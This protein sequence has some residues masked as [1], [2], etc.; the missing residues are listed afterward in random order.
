METGEGQRR[1]QDPSRLRWSSDL[2]H[3][4]PARIKARVTAWYLTKRAQLIRKR[5][6]EKAER[7]FRRAGA[8]IEAAIGPDFPEIAE[9]LIGLGRC[10]YERGQ[11]AEGLPVYERLARIYRAEFG[12][13]AQPTAWVETRIAVGLGETGRLD[14]AS[15]LL[16]G[17]LAIYERTYG[18]KHRYVAYV[19]DLLGE[20]SRLNN[21]YDEAIGYFERALAIRRRGF[22]H[23]GIKWTTT[24]LAISK[25]G[26]GVEQ[27]RACLLD[28][29]ESTLGQSRQLAL[30]IGRENEV[31]VLVEGGL[32]MVRDQQGRYRE[33]ENHFRNMYVK[34]VD[35]NDGPEV[36]LAAAEFL[37]DVLATL[38]R[39]PDALAP[40]HETIDWLG[41][42]KP[43]GDHA[44]YKARLVCRLARGE[45]ITN[46]MTQAAE[47]AEEALDLLKPPAIEILTALDIYAD[48][49]DGQGRCA[50]SYLTLLRVL[51]V[52]EELGGDNETRVWAL[53]NL[54]YFGIKHGRLD[55]EAR[56]AFQLALELNEKTLEPDD[57]E[58]E[59][60]LIDLAEFHRRT[61]P[62]TAVKLFERAM[63]IVAQSLGPNHPSLVKVQ[64][65]FA[66]TLM[67]ISAVNGDRAATI[68]AEAQR[69][70]GA[71]FGAT[72]PTFG[73]VLSGIARRHESL[74]N[75][76]QAVKEWRD[77]IAITEKVDVNHPDLV[78]DLDQLA[79][80]LEKLGRVE[81]AM[82]VQKRADQLRIPHQDL[83]PRFDFDSL[84]V[85]R[86]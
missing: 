17:D 33:A 64:V 78:D 20:A 2:P 38:S 77:C 53:R 5:Q 27:A 39:Y 35:D 8:L 40:L 37:A 7:L 13:S 66:S 75:V 71:T 29:A 74:G 70:A 67:D 31:R 30:D 36:R 28:A 81:E 14:E 22:R 60:S 79:G 73:Y 18:K 52:V 15:R 51:A 4:T 47:H 6:P 68:L 50:D 11:Y 61:D 56:E 84:R 10:L 58:I 9:S 83:Q 82:A 43:V 23:E 32:G 69:V 26:L 45:L 55:G 62:S 86:G 57:P 24:Q 12:D 65:D 3:Y 1:S 46:R 85:T 80:A 44:R 41:R 59:W 34:A 19:L 49:L 76:E 21:N 42:Q 25:G 54:G 48:V 16:Q 72:H 63:P